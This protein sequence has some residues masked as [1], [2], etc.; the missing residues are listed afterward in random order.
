MN[1]TTESRLDNLLNAN[2]IVLTPEQRAVILSFIEEET[3]DAYTRGSDAQS[4]A[5]AMSYSLRTD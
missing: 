3:S 4:Y 2:G 1:T 5:D